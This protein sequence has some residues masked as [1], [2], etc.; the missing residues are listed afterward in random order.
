MVR[1]IIFKDEKHKEFF[2]WCLSKGIQ[3]SYHEALYYC[4]GILNDTRQHINDIFDFSANEIKVECLKLPWQTGGT[5]QV[6]RL[7]FNLYTGSVPNIYDFQSEDEKLDEI[8]EYTVASIFYSPL[9]EFFWQA[10]KIRFEN[11]NLK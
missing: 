1:E 4:L 7:A 6:V 5:L 3:D 10:V 2:Q 11:F 8:L 9:A